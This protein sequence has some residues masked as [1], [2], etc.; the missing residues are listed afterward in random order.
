MAQGEGE[1]VLDQRVERRRGFK[2]AGIAHQ[3]AGAQRRAIELWPAPVEDVER[4][5][6]IEARF[7][8]DP[9]AMDAVKLLAASEELAA[10]DRHIGAVARIPRDYPPVESVKAAS[11]GNDI[12]DDPVTVPGKCPRL[13]QADDRIEHDGGIALP[14]EEVVR[15]GVIAGRDGR[16]EDRAAHGTDLLTEFG[17]VMQQIDG[18]DAPQHV[19]QGDRRLARDPAVEVAGHR[20]TRPRARRTRAGRAR[21]ALP[22][23]A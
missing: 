6:G 10:F 16:G 12:G 1:I 8:A 5:I 17:P 7:H 13:D 4:A 20:V 9:V 19:A 21:R 2:A 15:I 14:V 23:P 11:E 3:H 18:G 22:A